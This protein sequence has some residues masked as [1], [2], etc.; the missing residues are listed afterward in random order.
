M[1]CFR[2]VLGAVLL[3][4]FG[5]D[6]AAG[7]LP[8]FRV[9]TIG[10][11]DGFVSSVVADSRG[12]VYFTTTD[13]WIHRV[14]DGGQSV[15]VLAVP[16]KSGGN[17]GL[18][19]MALLDDR[20]AVVHYTTWSGEKV[21]DDVIAK[22]DLING[23]RAQLKAFAGDVEVRE[24]GVSDEHHG[25]NPTIGADGM[26]FVGIGEYAGRTIA[27]KPEWNGGKIWRIDPRTGD[28]TQ[29][30]IGMR[31]PYDLAWDPELEKIV[32]GDNGPDAGDEIHVVGEGSNCGWPLTFGHEP[33][34]EGTTAPVFTFDH[35]VAPTGLARLSG[36]NAML[37][38]GY[39][40]GAFVTRS[41]Y[42]FPDFT[43]QPAAIVDAFPE[44][45]IDVTQASDGAIYFATSNGAS[46]S[47]H[48][49]D[50]PPRGDCNG[51]G[52]TDWRDI[53]SL[54]ME[55][56]DGD[57]HA[58]IEAQDG[59]FAGSWGCD[60]NGDNLI[61]AA[62]QDALLDLISTRRRVVRH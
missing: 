34:V 17:G 19:G 48:R 52:V 41:I 5:L 7:V 1:K 11:A 42:Y 58:K 27:Q 50:V 39:L 3:F 21:L 2:S 37:S 25:G 62:D 26:V 49:L 10:R 31:N 35:T 56:G 12:F 16:T 15:R 28:A 8:G 57:S 51:D 30:A 9:E 6:A 60:A 46:S 43:K 47:I 13:G 36:A 59:M 4:L 32:V 14:V 53:L 20:S 29:W 45:V 44:F 38:K 23:T 18:L 22:V 55:V 24:R 54:M 61:N 33:Q 40:L